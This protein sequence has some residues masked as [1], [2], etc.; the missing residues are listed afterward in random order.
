MQYVY[1]PYAIL[2]SVIL[3]SATGFAG[4]ALAQGATPPAAA[5]STTIGVVDRQ[6]VITSFAKAQQ[7]AEELKKAEDSVRGMLESSNKQFED[8]K[9]AKK[10]QAELEA[11]QKRLQLKIDA[12]YTGAQK[13]AQQLEAQLEKDI[14]KAIKDEAAIH[15][16]DTV[17]VKDSV[18]LGGIDITDGVVKRLPATASTSTSSAKTVTK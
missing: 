5:K 4:Q 6:K 8:A 14:D 16:I 10:P 15:N 12:E 7:A 11:L 17:F 18:L 13:R 9:A 3:A 2:A 1:K